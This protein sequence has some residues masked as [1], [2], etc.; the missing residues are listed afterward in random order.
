MSESHQAVPWRRAVKRLGAPN[1]PALLSHGTDRA[2][3]VMSSPRPRPLA[4]A[5]V[6]SRRSAPS[7]PMSACAVSPPRDREQHRARLLE[8]ARGGRGEGCRHAAP[9]RSRGCVPVGRREEDGTPLAELGGQGVRV[10]L[11]EPVDGRSRDARVLERANLGARHG[12]QAAGDD[13]PR[14][15]LGHR[16]GRPRV[17]QMSARRLARAPRSPRGSR[18]ATRCRRRRARR[19]RPP[20]PRRPR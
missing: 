18:P 5:P 6:S 20:S 8:Q 2:A 4:G 3:R 12:M 11:V 7:A 9:G 15:S 19:G 16:R 17:A 14:A 1:P 10:G 13:E